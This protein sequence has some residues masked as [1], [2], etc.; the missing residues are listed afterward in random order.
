M[1]RLSL[2]A[3]ILLLVATAFTSAE[4]NRK[5]I[6]NLVIEN[7]PEIP[8]SLQ[9]RLEQ[10]QN[11]RSAGF[12]GWANDSKGIYILTRFSETA[13]VHFVGQPGG[14]R[15][16]LT[17]YKEPIAGIAVRPSKERGFLFSKD[18]GGNEQYQIYYFDEENGNVRMLS[19]GKS[20]YGSYQWSPDGE[21]FAYTSNERN[22]RDFDIYIYE[23]KSGKSQMV[24]EA[25]GQWSFL[26]FSSDGKQALI[27]NY[28]S[29]NESSVYL[30][31]LSTKKYEKLVE[32]NEKVAMG[33]AAFSK[34]G[35]GV[36]FLSNYGSEFKKLFYVDLKTKKITPITDAIDWDVE[37]ITISKDGA[38]LA[39]SVNA[40]GSSKVYIMNTKTFK[41]SEPKNLPKGEIGGFAFSPDSKKFA[42]TMNSSFSPGDVFVYSLKDQKAEQWTFSEVGGLNTSKF[43]EPVLIQYPTFDSVDGKPRMI[44]AYYYKPKGNGPFP[45]VIN[46][47]GGPEGQFRP[48]FASYFQFLLNELG[49]AVIAPNVRGSEGYG[50]T[51]LDLDNGFLRENSVK[52]GGALLD[53]IAKQ[54]ELDAKRI[55]V[56]GG[57]YGGYMVLAMLTH[58][59][60][61]LAAGIDVVG[62]SNFVTFLENT[63]EYRRDLRRVEYGDERNPEMRQ[64]LEKISPLN[65]AHKISKPLF[66]IQGLNDPRVPTSEAEQIVAKVRQ[67]GGDVWYLLAKDEGHG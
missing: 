30:L 50:K 39:F 42:F 67:N 35:K 27:Y 23:F 10:Y 52:D 33:D 13:Q 36:F 29:I 22:N 20:R 18:I 47:H 38:N 4:V 40:N 49:V 1:K 28:I 45:V 9:E 61:R 44:P 51:F 7:I 31:D 15:R 63:S 21:K 16:Q 62:I 6:G 43:I 46:F 65:N 19:N 41:Y 53:W 37:G 58:Y 12:A 34:D 48:G 24:F 60:D 64:F 8:A 5:E 3:M 55:C 2:L 26:D 25:K 56:Y 54:P 32:Y 57:S 17:F 14:A 11:V 66:V 59:N